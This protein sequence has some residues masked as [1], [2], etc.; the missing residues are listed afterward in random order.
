VSTDGHRMV[1]EAIK[2]CSTDGGRL[3]GLPGGLET[4]GKAPDSDHLS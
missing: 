2:W 4:A 1:V 3:D